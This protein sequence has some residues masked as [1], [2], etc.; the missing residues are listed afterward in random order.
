MEFTERL[1]GL[2]RQ[3]GVTAYRVRKDLKL[4]NSIVAYWLSGQKFPDGRNLIKLADYFGVSL[5]YLVGRSD[6][7]AVK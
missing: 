3:R 5:D 2:M 1:A 7:P 4:S 6:D